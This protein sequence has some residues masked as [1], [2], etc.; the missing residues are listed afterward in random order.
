VERSLLRWLDER[1]YESVQQLRGSV[2][3]AAATDPEAFERANYM[4]ELASFSSDFT[5]Q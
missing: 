4:K 5:A 1:E 2:S 3:H